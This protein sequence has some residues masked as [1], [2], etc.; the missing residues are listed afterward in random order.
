MAEILLGAMIM[1]IGVVLG[2]ALAIAAGK[3]K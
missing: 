2:Y 3:A 1:L